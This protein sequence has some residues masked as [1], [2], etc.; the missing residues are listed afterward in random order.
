MWDPEERRP[1]VAL[2]KHGIVLLPPPPRPSQHQQRRLGGP[3]HTDTKALQFWKMTSGV[4]A[5]ALNEQS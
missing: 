5:G 4:S 1:R 2:E 3:L